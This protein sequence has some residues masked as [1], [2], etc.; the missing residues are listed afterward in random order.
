MLFRLLERLRE[1]DVQRHA[2]IAPHVDVTPGALERSGRGRDPVIGVHPCAILI[3]PEW[4]F[5]GAVAGSVR[6][7]ILVDVD[8]IAAQPGVVG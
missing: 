7:S 1:G 5:V 8:H 2:H 3:I 4:I 6:E